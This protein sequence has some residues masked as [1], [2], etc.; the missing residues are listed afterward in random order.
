MSLS[1]FITCYRPTPS[2][3]QAGARGLPPRSQ[4]G[5]AE[6]PGH[7]GRVVHRGAAG[8]PGRD[9]CGRMAGVECGAVFGG[10]AGES[11]LWPFII[12]ASQVVNESLHP[13]CIP[14]SCSSRRSGT[15]RSSATPIWRPPLEAVPEP[16]SLA[17]A[18]A[19]G[20]TRRRRSPRRCWPTRPAASAACREAEA[21]WSPARARGA[22]E[23]QR[24]VNALGCRREEANCPGTAL[25][26]PVTPPPGVTP[27]MGTRCTVAACRG[28]GGRRRWPGWRR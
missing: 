28:G 13:L 26:V 19:T 18:G 3:P 15:R 4:A 27:A 23:L 2:S 7:T 25:S 6:C 17:A 8:R 16:P 21:Q 11:G 5:A 12:L 24:T 22:W 1:F 20:A 10:R 14:R 9:G